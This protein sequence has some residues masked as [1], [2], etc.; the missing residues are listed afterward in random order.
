MDAFFQ[1][2][3]VSFAILFTY[4][5]YSSF[6]ISHMRGIFSMVPRNFFCGK[7]ENYVWHGELPH[8]ETGFAMP[9]N[10]HAWQ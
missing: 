2:T 10:S 1:I 8:V 7:T 6:I 4:L 9:R 5:Q 3:N